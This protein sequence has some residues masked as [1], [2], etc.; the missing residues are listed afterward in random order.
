MGFLFSDVV[1]EESVDVTTFGVVANGIADD[2]VP[3]Q[4]A[5]T[6]CSEGRLTCVVPRGARIRI[7]KPLYLWSGGS[8]RGERGSEFLL[9]MADDADR[10]VFNLGIRGR[11]RIAQPHT[12]S[13][14]GLKFRI[15]AGPSDKWA[16]DKSPIS[17]RVIQFWNVDGS[18]I[19]GNWF[20]LGSFFYGATA[21]QKNKA[22][23]TGPQSRRGIKILDNEVHAEAVAHGM[24][25]L[26]VGYCSEVEIRGN[27]VVGVG[28]DPIGIHFCEDVVVAK[29]RTRGVD[30]RIYISNSKRV[31]VRNNDVRR[32]PSP[33]DGKFRAGTALIWVG[34]DRNARKLWPEP[35]DIEI[36]DNRLEYPRDAID[37]GGAISIQGGDRIKVTSN[38]VINHSKSV[39][40]KAVSL[41]PYFDLRR[42]QFH[43]LG[44]VTVVDNSATGRYPLVID[45]SRSRVADTSK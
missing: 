36:S 21:A 37:T 9:A 29:N 8:L 43:Q 2:T 26:S 16:D 6:H 4:T 12:G 38:K 31:L 19:Q 32:S 28:D 11:Q 33:V 35:E 3:M 15:L 45:P 5:L 14:S 42:L 10:F 1:A 40:A 39:R 27:L 20:S 44:E 18:R 13:I 41:K 24:E 22:W 34:Y 23:L 30:G 25:G 7:T 17:G